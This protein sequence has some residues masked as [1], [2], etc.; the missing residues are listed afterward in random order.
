MISTVLKVIEVSCYIAS[1]FAIGFVLLGLLY[2]GAHGNSLWDLMTLRNSP[3]A[4]MGMVSVI[5][6]LLGLMIRKKL[7]NE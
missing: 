7:K 5:F 1:A 2:L 3:Y 6:A 4:F